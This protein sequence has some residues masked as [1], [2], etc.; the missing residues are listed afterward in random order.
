MIFFPGRLRWVASYSFSEIRYRQTQFFF[1]FSFFLMVQKGFIVVRRKKWEKFCM[2]KKLMNRKRVRYI[3]FFMF[4]FIYLSIYNNIHNLQAVA[5]GLDL[6]SSEQTKKRHFSRIK[7]NF[8]WL[9]LNLLIRIIPIILLLWTIPAFANIHNTIN[10]MNDSLSHSN[11]CLNIFG[12]F[13]N[14]SNSVLCAAGRNQ[15]SLPR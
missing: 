7:D 8:S 4:L 9:S 5:V 3:Y 13:G 1:F 12:N 2:E 10:K 15:R 11:K 6:I 14:L